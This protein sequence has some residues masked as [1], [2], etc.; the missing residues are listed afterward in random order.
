MI[1]SFFSFL[2][3]R[4]IMIPEALDL[5]TNSVVVNFSLTCWG[6]FELKVFDSNELINVDSSF[7]F[8]DYHWY[9][10]EGKPDPVEVGEVWES[11]T[12]P[13]PWCEH[14][15]LLYPIVHPKNLVSQTFVPNHNTRPPPQWKK[16]GNSMHFIVA[17]CSLQFRG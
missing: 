15:E 4:E 6:P 16:W 13:E 7:K 17:A 12:L 2:F 9:S 5:A 8:E 14:F 1:S 11:Q 3:F 10:P